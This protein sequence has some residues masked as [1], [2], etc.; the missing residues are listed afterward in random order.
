MPGACPTR[1][2][3]TKRGLKPD[4]HSRSPWRRNPADENFP[5]EEGTETALTRSA[6]GMAI[7]TDEN[8][9]DEEGTETPYRPVLRAASAAPDENFPD[10]EGTE[11][12]I[13]AFGVLVFFGRRE[14]PRRRGD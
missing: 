14:L 7:V 5:D 12:V 8:F 2:S 13:L 10:E 9:P 3:P 6:V 1:T 4:S 11:T